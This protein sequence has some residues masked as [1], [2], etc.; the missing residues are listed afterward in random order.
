MTIKGQR[1]SFYGSSPEKAKE[2]AQA[3][4]GTLA[5][6]EEH[7]ADE[8]A[9]QTF[10]YQA[11][12]SIMPLY[13]LK[14]DRTKEAA[15]YALN[16][17][18]DYWGDIPAANLTQALTIE[19][20]NKFAIA[21]PN[22]Y[23]QRRVRTYLRK[24]MTYL[25]REGTIRWNYADEIEASEVSKRSEIPSAFEAARFLQAIE[26]DRLEPKLWLE[27]M[28]G[29]ADQEANSLEV[30]DWNGSDLHV[31][32]TKTV[33]RDGTIPIPR[34]MSKTLD[35]FAQGKKR[36]FVEAVPGHR[37]NS[38][39]SRD[40]KTLAKRHGFKYFS[41]HA[42]RHAFASGL[43][44]LGCPPTIR[45]TLMRQSTKNS[46]QHLYVHPSP[47][48]LRDWL[49]KWNAHCSKCLQASGVQGVVRLLEENA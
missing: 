28:L 20:W 46:V 31:R 13:A 47:A 48:I 43:E 10:G 38:N 32:G 22:G 24:A 7:T 1:K 9:K 2:K 16:H 23:T 27:F 42:Y 35:R 49:G 12:A 19:R 17:I 45:M 26:G 5:K 39:P 37:Y 14:K 36:Y 6:A 3:Y 33:N 29:L 34:C 25:V 41:N 15:V 8:S 30:A 11:V 40:F 4:S 18:V 44:E 21:Y